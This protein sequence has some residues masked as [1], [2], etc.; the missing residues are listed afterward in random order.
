LIAGAAWAAQAQ[1]VF[2][3]V[4][5]LGSKQSEKT[6][7]E[8]TGKGGNFKRTIHTYRME[9]IEIMLRNTSATS[10]DYVVEWMFLS[11]PAKGGG[12]PQPCAADEKTVTLAPNINSTF[13]VSSPKL[14][15]TQKYQHSFESHK[16]EAGKREQREKTRYLGM[17]GEKPA[18]FVVRVKAGGKILA[19]DASDSTLERRY[20]NPTA[21]WAPPESKKEKEDAPDKPG[22]KK[23]PVKK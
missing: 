2:M 17:D 13:Q 1:T 11:S 15:A 10:V 18:G 6:T 7:T 23:K 8:D 14:E 9:S 12:D 3:K 4:T 21:P 19:V 20:Q 16:N 22:P 5:P